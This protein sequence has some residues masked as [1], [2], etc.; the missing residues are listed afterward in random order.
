MG[1]PDTTSVLRR[2]RTRKKRGPSLTARKPRRVR[3]KVG[4]RVTLKSG[5]LVMTVTALRS[6]SEIDAI[7]C[8]LGSGPDPKT[9]E[10]EWFDKTRHHSR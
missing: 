1:V 8:Q 5:G 6:D 2:H 9:V 10:C 4:D 7:V 3:H